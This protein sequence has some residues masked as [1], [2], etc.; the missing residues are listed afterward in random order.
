MRTATA[1]LTLALLAHAHSSAWS[2]D[3]PA[4]SQTDGMTPSAGSPN[5]SGY[6]E[7]L[8]MHPFVDA[9]GTVIVEMPFPVSWKVAPNPRRGEPTITGPNHVKVI[10]FPAQSFL[11]TSDPQMQQV[12][13]RGGQPLR[14]MP[15]I[16]QLIQQDLAPWCASQGLEFIRHYEVP[17]VARIDKW[18]NDQLY[19]ALPADIMITAIGTEWRHSGGNLFFMLVHLNVGNGG[20]LQT[21]SYYC[22]GLQAEKSHFETAKRQLLFGLANARYNPQPIMEYNKAEAQRV[23]KSWEEHNRRLARN[24]AAF[25][26]SQRAF[27]NRSQSIHDSIMKG[28]N[29]R[30]AASDKAHEQF[31]DAITERTQV[32]DP[33]T[34][35]RYKVEGLSNQYWMNRDGEYFGTDNPYY[36]PNRDENMNRQN[37]RKLEAVK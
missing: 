9:K 15:G 27:V 8:A 24:Q 14:P 1:C 10:D 20:N 33:A 30:N 19:K 28:W 26:A 35:N 34:G 3:H 12:Y 37:W 13:L 6:W 16:E 11:Y 29:D 17:E 25:E 7:K 36:D 32:T 4:G 21:W 22:N 23:G 2:Q 5:P 31:V 18:Y